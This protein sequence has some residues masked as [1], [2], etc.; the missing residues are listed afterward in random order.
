MRWA[1]GDFFG[2]CVLESVGRVSGALG[3]EESIPYGIGGSRFVL[4]WCGGGRGYDIFS[5]G[6]GMIS[7]LGRGVAWGRLPRGI[8]KNKLSFPGG[9]ISTVLKLFAVTELGSVVKPK[10]TATI[11]GAKSKRHSANLAE[12]FFLKNFCF[13]C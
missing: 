6:K 3:M 9:V 11:R 1:L 12:V 13:M 5:C 4:N 2:L 8:S 10:I 7:I